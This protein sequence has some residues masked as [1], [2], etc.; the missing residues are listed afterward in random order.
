LKVEQ[1][2]SETNKHYPESRRFTGYQMFLEATDTFLHFWP[3][4]GSD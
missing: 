3:A 2:F 4:L 1:I